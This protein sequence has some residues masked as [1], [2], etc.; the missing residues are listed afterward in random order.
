MK[1]YDVK[2]I[3]E[4]VSLQDICADFGIPLTKRGRYTFLPCPNPNH[5]DK[6]AT[7]CYIKNNNI[8]CFACAYHADAVQLVADQLYNGDTKKH[9]ADILEYLSPYAGGINNFLLYDTENET[10]KEDRKKAFILQKR[11]KLMSH[12][13]IRNCSIYAP[14]STAFYHNGDI[15]QKVYF[16]DNGPEYVEQ[17][18]ICNLLDAFDEKFIDD[19]LKQKTFD[20]INSLK[21]EKEELEDLYKKNPSSLIIT[22]IAEVTKSLENLQKIA[23]Y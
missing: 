10:S 7:N 15:N 5:N 4:N 22:M 20:E 13:G 21:E 8:Y 6:N 3:N 14:V 18:K 11:R 23:L 9:F 19:M 2:A 1:K 16:K 12:F 17:E